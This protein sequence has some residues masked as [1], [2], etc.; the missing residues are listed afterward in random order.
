MPI[1]WDIN[2]II[3]S[4]ITA[5]Y[6]SFAAL[7]HAER[8]RSSSGK[9]AMAWMVAGGVTLG[10]SIWSMHFIGMLAFHLPVSITYD[11]TLTFASVLP[12]I[13][14]ALLGFYILQSPK[15]HIG[16]I[17]FGGL[18][19]GLAISAMHYTGMAALKMQPAISYNPYIFVLSL[20][21]AVIA[22]IGALLIVYAGEKSNLN[23]VVR[24]S[25]GSLIMGL[26]I[27]GM[28]YTGMAATSFALGSVCTVDGTSVDPTLLSFFIAGIVF[29][30]VT[31]GWIA[32]LLDK[33]MVRENAVALIQLSKQTKEL[34]IDRD[35]LEKINSGKTL[36]VVLN[37]LVKQVEAQ[38]PEMICT[39]L[40]LDKEGKHLLLVAAPSMPEIYNQALDGFEI[41]KGLGSCG[42]AAFTGKR[43]VVED[44][45]KHPNW[46]SYQHL[47]KQGNFRACWAQPIKN[48]E[49]RVLGTF[50]I[51]HQS[52]TT[53]D[54]NDI[55]LIERYAHLSQLVL[56]RKEHEDEI[57]FIAF[58]D[59]LTKLP[60]RRLL[61]DRLQQAI[62][63][64]DRTGHY[65][66]VIF[67][68]LDNFKHVND[69]RGHDV[70]DKLL[71]EVASR[72][73]KHMRKGDTVA[74]LG[75]D[76][77]IVMTTDLG[78]DYN[79]SAIQAEL[80]CEKIL[81]I[82]NEPFILNAHEQNCT[83]SIGISI[84]RGNTLSVANLLKHA[85]TAM[86]QSKYAG[87]N[88][89]HF[90]D[91]TMQDAIEARLSIQ[92]DLRKAISENQFEL[93]YQIQVDRQN[94][95]LG[96]EALIRWNHPERGRVPPLEFIPIAE[97]TGAIIA[98]GHFVLMTA[99]K[100]LKIWESN[101]KTKDLLLA[102]NVS[103]YQFKQTDF[104]DEVKTVLSETNANPNLLKIELTESM[105]IDNVDEIINKM[106]QLRAIGVRFSMDDFGTGYSSLASIKHLPITQLKI[107]KSF[108]DDIA[109]NSNDA[110]I[111]KT[112]IAMGN[113]LGL[114][115]IAEGVENED[116]F[117]ILKDFDCPNFQGYLFGKPMPIDEFE[118]LIQDAMPL[119]GTNI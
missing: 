111:A 62:D 60:N 69:T 102:I 35:I 29:L 104:V 72:L 118:L 8:M 50:A 103:L 77:F 44:V 31:G 52:P 20:L 119:T 40:L 74:R 96:A 66:A 49:N 67:I 107:D 113:I 2:L 42:E 89:W 73:S 51:Y 18:M 93:Y 30:L 45:T 24:H 41:G 38:H 100:Q 80:I 109:K 85:D 70:G 97:E 87:R 58:H 53:P 4:V 64:S 13:L 22:A 110:A 83:A 91:P 33:R 43:V 112:I 63:A 17:M 61:T 47:V 27:A 7:S 9:S 48:Y 94:K 34:E 23:S 79:K 101:P 46:A 65:G 117:K 57:S 82:L 90:F 86:Y 116:Q 68:D 21:I 55:S 16:K 54:E 88:T 10:L 56:E 32:N 115:V 71:A 98:I 3:L 78:D 108:V 75:G 5:M 84:F 59:P 14:A 6:G 99:C 11:L 15:M 19:M 95:T 114:N 26:A 106:Q 12:A 39:I 37:D 105:V 28:H 25:I 92:S 1:F 81:S 36:H 76:E